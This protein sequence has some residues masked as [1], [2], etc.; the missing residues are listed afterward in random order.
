MHKWVDI[1]CDEETV[2]KVK[3]GRFFVMNLPPGRHALSAR[4]GIPVFMETRSG[5][6]S[7]LRLG[8]QIDGQTAMLV[9][10]KIDSIEFSGGYVSLTGCRIEATTS[11]SES[12]GCD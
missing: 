4:E 6:K 1:A 2:A 8:Q 12:S 3:A 7:F 11:T 10:T 5:E 9:P